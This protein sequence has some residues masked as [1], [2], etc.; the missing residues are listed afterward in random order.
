MPPPLVSGW[1]CTTCQKRWNPSS[2]VFTVVVCQDLRYFQRL[3]EKKIFLVSKHIP[4]LHLSLL[5]VI[6]RDNVDRKHLFF[7][8]HTSVLCAVRLLHSLQEHNRFTFPQTFFRF[9]LRYHQIF[10]SGI[11]TQQAMFP[12][13]SLNKEPNVPQKKIP[14]TFK[15][16]YMKK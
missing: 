16:K 2:P 12:H 13:L 10:N 7:Q 3:W 9:H 8:V 14:S 1:T 5:K 15:R 6:T 4:N 11:K